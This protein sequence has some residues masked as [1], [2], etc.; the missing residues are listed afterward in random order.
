MKNTEGEEKKMASAEKIIKILELSIPLIE[1]FGSIVLPL[2]EKLIEQAIRL[3]EEED[4]H[5][6]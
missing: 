5:G 6:N 2:I 4:R 3:K 1:K